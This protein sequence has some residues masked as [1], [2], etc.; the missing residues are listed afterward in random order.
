MEVY[1]ALGLSIGE[2]K[3]YRS[4]IL[5]GSSTTGPIYKKAEVS[6]SKVYEILDR[7]KKKGLVSSITK[8][9]NTYWHAANPSI[10]LEKLE[11]EY[12][13]LKER[14]AIL[15]AG[16]P[17]LIEHEKTA[18]D[19]AQIFHGYN[20]FRTALMSFQESF[21]KGDCL[22]VFGSPKEIPEPFYSFLKAYNVER[23]KR[24]VL[25][26][27]IY[28]RSL[29]TFAS[30]RMYN[31]P[32]TEVR[33]IDGT[34]ASIGIGNDRILLFSFEGDGKVT[35]IINPDLADNFREFFDSLWKTAKNK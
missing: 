33:F 31:L 23:V 15:K 20:G 3:V 22:R 4:L 8:E 29:K 21:N 11:N 34:P 25:G 12:R 19:E 6:Q 26:K 1:E 35:V 28:G 32:K 5:L 2:E 18:Y 16:L 13:Q 30:E 10:Y 9:G 14:K 17:K 7:L 24:G 27:W